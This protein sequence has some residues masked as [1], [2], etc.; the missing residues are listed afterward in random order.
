MLTI[1]T[2]CAAA[3]LTLALPFAVPAANAA[4]VTA[5]LS[6]ATPMAK[7]V[8]SDLTQVQYR[9]R[10]WG[11]PGAVIGGLAAGAIIGGAIAASRPPGY[12]YGPGYYDQGYYAPPPP[13]VVYQ[14]PA[15]GGGDA[16][17]YC[18]QRYRSY[19]PASGT[20]LNLDGNRYPCP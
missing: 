2:A 18:M 8:G 17:A 15:Y 19:D 16:E 20:Y 4:P 7:S 6:L 12:Y 9:R 14:Q 11:G 1:R 10:G 13:P 5:G 3:A